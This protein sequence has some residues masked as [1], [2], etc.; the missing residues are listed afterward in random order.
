MASQIAE[1]SYSIGDAAMGVNY[2]LDKVRFPNA[3]PVGGEIRGRTELMEY[4]EIPGGAR[5]KMKIT[6]ELKGDEKPVC[7]AEF[8]A[9]IYA[10]AAQRKAFDELMAKENA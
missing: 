9:Q 8:I 6:F 4:K 1:K 5:F 7:V 2:G 10:N 3:T